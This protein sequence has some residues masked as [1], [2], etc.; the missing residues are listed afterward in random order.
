MKSATKLQLALLVGGITLTVLLFIAKKT[1]SVAAKK[2]ENTKVVAQNVIKD[3]VVKAISVLDKRDKAKFVTL[4]AEYNNAKPLLKA[5]CLDTITK[6][7]DNLNLPAVAS[8]FVEEKA[9]VSNQAEHWFLAG[10][11][12]YRSVNFI[13]QNELRGPFYNQAIE[14]IDKGL[15]LE[16][17]N[18]EARVRKAACIV[19]GS[20]FNGNDPMKGITILR[21]LEKE[22]STNI[23]LQIAFAMFSLKSQQFDRAI[24]RFNKIVKL[25]PDYLEAYLYLADVHKLQGDTLSAIKDLENL[26]LNCKDAETRKVIK[27][28]I[29]ELK[30]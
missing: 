26:V 11:R 15:A 28:S 29:L 5:Q 21:E 23:N 12:Y 13:E 9:K 20:E 30:K 8:Y 7:W 2:P 24:N 14:C 22:D 19:D 3:F 27:E 16:P 6:F 1:P 10:E 18:F 25:K 17:K 4:E